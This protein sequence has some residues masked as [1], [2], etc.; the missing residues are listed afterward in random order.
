MQHASSKDVQH[1][2]T[3]MNER[4]LLA[5]RIEGL[6]EG[7]GQARAAWERPGV[8]PHLRTRISV[9]FDKLFG[10]YEKAL[11]AL[12]KRL[13][14]GA[15]I[16]ECWS[17]FERKRQ[18]CAAVFREC[19]A[20]INGAIARSKSVGLDRGLCRIADA[21]L[22][23]LSHATEVAWSRFTILGET[24]SF[25]GTAEIIRLRFPELGVWSLPLLGHEFGHLV[26]REFRVPRHVGGYRYP[27]REYVE[28]EAQATPIEERYLGERFAD[29]F[30]VYALGPAP[31]F[32]A[33]WLRFDPTSSAGAE[34]P[35]DT[36]RVWLM[37]RT[38]ELMDE[39]GTPP[40]PFTG[41]AHRLRDEW[42]VTEK[43]VG[44]R[45]HLDARVESALEERVSALFGLLS[46]HMPTV[47]YDSGWQAQRLLDRFRANAEVDTRAL[48][49]LCIPDV[50]NAAWLRR[51]DEECFMPGFALAIDQRSLEICSLL[52]P[53]ARA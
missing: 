15:A 37:L 9:R 29:M 38:L 47:R 26:A 23:H 18:D 50:L 28:R 11:D 39:T 7:M 46:E 51:M 33:I 4:R 44:A 14:N 1:H 13:S 30:A 20:L 43:S 42:R 45:Q 53:A 25:H 35:A 21:L 6:R 40:S 24:E 5:A 19:L 49:A 8:D 22:D 32:A 2:T 41:I 48:D 16:D 52:V 12:S 27:F 10:Q 34:H 31:I 36:E 17:D 3:S